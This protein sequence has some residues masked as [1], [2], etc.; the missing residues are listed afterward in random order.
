MTAAPIL[1]A[2]AVGWQFDGRRVLDDVDLEVGRGE[3]L[4][5]VGPNGAGKTTLLRILVGLLEP[6]SGTVSLGGARLTSLSRR[7]RARHL[8]YVPQI[9]PTRVPLTVEQMVLLGR[10]P[11]LSPFRGA[12]RGSDFEAVGRALEEVGIGGLR[13]RLLTELSG[14]EQQAVYVA[15]ALAQEAEVMILDEPT[16]H[17]DP[18]HQREIAALLLE[19][20]RKGEKT[21]VAATHDLNFASLIAD[22]IFA[23]RGGRT[24]ACDVPSRI[25][26][27]ELLSELFRAPFEIVREGERPVTLL[28]LGR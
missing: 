14:G 22:R 2:E 11:Y 15:T 12:P 6:S 27:P 1:V 19:L 10:Y 13:E 3:C 26:Q 18:S 4:V 7:E 25:L 21:V 9:R 20:N 17:L 16:T 8:A 28:E 5:V 24:L 23:L